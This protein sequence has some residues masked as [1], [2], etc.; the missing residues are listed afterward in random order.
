MKNFSKSEKSLIKMQ[1]SAARIP[2][3]CIFLLC[4]SLT[5]LA[6]FYSYQRYISEQEA[7]FERLTRSLTATIEQRFEI[8]IASLYHTR[9]L[10]KIYP[11]ITLKKFDTFIEA[12]K[13]D[14]NFPG[15]RGIGYTPKIL[16]NEIPIFE[17]KI[18]QRDF[19]GYK[20]HGGENKNHLQNEVHY[21]VAAFHPMDEI[22]RKAMGYDTYSE[23]NRRAAMDRAI[24]SG[25]PSAT[26]RLEF[27]RGSDN[28]RKQGFIIYVPY[29]KSNMPIDT[30]EERR[31]AI[32]GFVYS[33]YRSEVFFNFLSALHNGQKKQFH[34]E[35][36]E[37]IHNSNEAPSQDQLIF[38]TIDEP[39][40][41]ENG[42]WGRTILKT[43]EVDVGNLKW[44]IHF[45]SLSGFTPI[46]IYRFPLYAAIFGFII[47]CLITLILL[48]SKNQSRMLMKDIEL[49]QKA[50]HEL[51][52]EK[53]MVELIS[54]IGLNLKAESDLKDIVQMVTD[55]ATD[56]TDAKFG[57]FFYNTI[58]ATG[59]I[60]TLY[61]LSG[62]PPEAFSKFPMPRKTAI[63]GPTFDGAATIRSH[64]ILKDPRYGKMGAPYHGM[65]AGHLPVRSY[66]AAPVRS[67]K[68]GKVLGGL[69]FGHPEPGIF[70]ENAEKIVEAISAQAAVAM[71]NANLYAE[72]RET[73]IAAQDANQAKSN[74]LAN[75]SHEIRTPLGII[76]G[77]ADLA[78]EK[79]T[80]FPENLPEY[81]STIKK[82]GEELTRIVGEVLDLSKIE[83]N[84]LEIEKIKFNLPKFLDD[85]VSFLNLKAK[86]KGI[87][88]SL[89]KD[90][91]LPEN[92]ISDPTRLRQIITNLVGNAI[93]FTEK[94]S[95]TLFVRSL[96][97]DKEFKL[98]FTIEDTG[99]GISKD[100]KSKL[101]KPFSQADTSTTRKYGGSGL[102][103]LL[104]RQL[105]RVMGGDLDIEWS[106]PLK[107]SRFVFTITAEPAENHESIRVNWT[108]E[109]PKNSSSSGV[110]NLSD[111]KILVVEDSVDNQFLIQHYLK[112][113]QAQVQ[114]SNNGQEA[115]D[116]VEKFN[117]DLILM[118]IQM[119]I[120]DGYS[121][122]EQLRKLGF[123]KPIIAL[124]AHAINDER[125]RAL[126][127]GFDDYLTKPLDKDLLA[128]TMQKFLAPA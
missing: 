35:I 108:Q 119:P 8:Y 115:I 64:D 47:S 89:N 1:K 4:I 18:S 88:L 83:A 106:E 34:M 96:D 112:I 75:M 52:D 13:L 113:F 94:G 76:I 37:G 70:T 5:A 90:A 25:R 105:S 22:V 81:L 17:R 107:G 121:A 42:I 12:L 120:L 62:A 65:P 14:E 50:E 56:L 11:D 7:R 87:L 69:F 71:D 53:R 41:K 16:T 110:V 54:K 117:P 126:Q 46:E 78:L 19:P 2:V 122:T 21:P 85:V 111:K 36:Y 51:A 93:K 72:L 73:Q 95:V 109:K 10:L 23:P 59:E 6:T 48:L 39:Q 86:E 102:G 101:F 57:A 118:D 116:E 26:P 100:Q 63:F 98:A 24:E 58:D 125:D 55:T 40:T 29:F 74:F 60:L 104:S 128:K 31:A 103:L 45:S 123:K 20:I 33:T 66:L 38:K 9:S 127:S 79:Q 68:T 124:T 43:T 82:N 61:T 97:N 32:A 77:Y 84:R 99:I 67:A 30:P 28:Q 80:K 3:W 15:I 49:R 27:M 91:N 44:T 92:I 114:I